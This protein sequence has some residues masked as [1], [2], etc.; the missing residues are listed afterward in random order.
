[1]MAVAQETFGNIR[2]VKAFADED[3]AYKSF[4]KK[5]SDLYQ[6]GKVKSYVLGA[7]MF[8]YKVF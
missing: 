7:F 3:G 1:M 5:N 4:S 6:I 2:T 8:C